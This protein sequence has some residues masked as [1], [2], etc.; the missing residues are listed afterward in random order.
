MNDQPNQATHYPHVKS[1]HIS[2]TQKL[3][4]E[5]QNL[6]VIHKAHFDSSVAPGTHLF[7]VD[8][9]LSPKPRKLVE[10]WQWYL[11]WHELV[12]IRKKHLLRI[13]AVERGKSNFSIMVEKSFI[14][15]LKLDQQVAPKNKK[16]REGSAFQYMV[17]AG[18]EAGPIW[19]WLISHHGIADSLAAQILAHIDDIG[20]FDSIAK[21]WR[22][23]GYGIFEYWVDKDGKAICPKEGWKWGTIKGEKYRVWTVIDQRERVTYVGDVNSQKTQETHRG[24][25]SNYSKRATR[26]NDVEGQTPCVTHT[27]DVSPPNRQYAIPQSDKLKPIKRVDFLKPDPSWTLKKMS[28]RLCPKYHSP[29]NRIFKAVMWNVTEQFIKG[30]TPYYRPMY[31]Y[32]KKR[33]RELHPKMIK[34]NSKKRYNDGHIN[35][36]AKRKIRKEF[37]K[38]LWLK[39]R[40]FEGLP[41]TEKW[42]ANTDENQIQAR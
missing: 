31:D 34:V 12:E 13:S 42:R 18:K 30:R 22:Y 21:L 5:N 40:E 35:D 37:L 8:D 25:A 26:S 4:A 39:W 32:G 9:R 38:Q 14:E 17:D 11:I 33:L 15:M 23:A 16:E 6:D 29:F 2:E 24:N 41:I 7:D 36:M 28:D 10:L 1:Q 3:D 27:R 20:N 19:D